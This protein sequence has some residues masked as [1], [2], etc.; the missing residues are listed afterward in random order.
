LRGRGLDMWR[1]KSCTRC[2]GDSF[3]EKDYY[4]WYERC[5]QCGYS[6]DMKMAYT[7]KRGQIGT[8]KELTPVGATMAGTSSFSGHS[9]KPVYRYDQK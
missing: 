5:L 4:G 9:E 3:I 6:K 7:D 1:L 8:C 2:N